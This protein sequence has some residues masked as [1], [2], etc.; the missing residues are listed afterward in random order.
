MCYRCIFRLL[1]LFCLT[2]SASAQSTSATIS[3]QVTDPSGRVIPGADIQILNEATGVRYGNTSNGIGIYSVSILPPGQYRVQVSKRGFKTLIKPDVILNVQS[4]VAVNFTMPPG[5]ASE[6]ITVD[7]GTS[8][9]NSVD[10]SVSTVIDK[11]F[12]ENMPLN[13]RS[14]Q[15][16][17][18]LTPGITTQ[19]PQTQYQAPGQN[20]DFSVNGQRTESNNYM[21]DGV[22]GNVNPGAAIGAPQASSSG[23][24]GATTALGTT[25]SLISVDA[26]Q[27]FRVESSSYSAEFGRTP[28]GQ[29]SLQTRAGTNALHGAIFDYLRNNFFDANDWF[30]N[31]YGRPIAALRQNDFGGTL[32]GPATIPRTYSGKDRTF[33]FGSYEGLRLVQ[34][35]AATPQ[36][37]PDLSMRRQAPDVLRPILNAYPVPNGI[38]YGTETDPNLAQFIE[39]YS[40]PSNIDSTSVRIDHTF[41]PL[42]S[43]FFRFGNTPSS[44]STRTLSVLNRVHNNTQTYTLGA[45]SAFSSLLV[46]EFRIG[47]SR[48]D[49]DTIGA[50]DAFGGA[51]PTSL[52]TAFGNQTG[53]Y[54]DSSFGINIPTI[55]YALLETDGS[56]NSIRQWN[57]VNNT[58]IALGRHQLKFGVDYRRIVSPF[59]PASPSVASLYLTPQSVL[60]NTALFVDIEKAIG[61]T[62]TFNETSVFAQD[63]WQLRPNLHLSFGVRWEINPPP[64]ESNGNLPYTLEGNIGQPATLSL[65]SKGTALWKTT[66]LNFAPRLGVS[67]TAHKREGAETVVSAGGGVFFDTDNQLAAS[68]F[69]GLGFRASNVLYGAA[70][71]VTATQLDSVSP[72]NVAAPYTS[73]IPYVF[74]SHLQLPYTLEWNV[75]LQQALGKLQAITVSYVGANGRR[76]IQQQIVSVSQANPL[77]G[78]VGYIPNGLTSSYQALQLKFQRTVHSGINALAAYTWSHS[79]DF[80]SNNASL[81]VARGNSDFDVR[82]SLQAGLSWDVPSPYQGRLGKK[83]FG[84]WGLDGRL[85]ARSG[86]PVTLRGNTLVNPV[87]GQQYYSGVN[88]DPSKPVYLFGG[89]YPGGRAINGG[90]SAVNPA[91]TA[92]PGTTSGNASRNFVRGFGATQFN[93]AL[94]R[95]FHLYDRASL[96]FRAEAFNVSN[97]PNFGYVNSILSNALFGQATGMLNQSLG[98][99]SSLY[100]QGGPRSMQLAL[101][102]IF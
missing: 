84:Q 2:A 16:L 3:G 27:E 1:L 4:A 79:L 21:V 25:Q 85:I 36:Y 13:G 53:K 32:G 88:Y 94:R 63:E 100:Q 56:R 33:F 11:T 52:A 86:F 10:S 9:V 34:P 18:S 14:F 68:G 17:I 15:D 96:Q 92:P 81:P 71:P 40:L 51:T 66:W 98:S 43:L 24:V 42:L 50:V 49:A 5:A 78:T 47:Y 82:N 31:Y 70:L 29:F 95:Q 55:G 39:S 26:L 90:P 67:W 28:G 101:K 45:T 30:N 77:F 20:G 76:L 48:G 12:V 60:A 89:Q 57:L 87:N 93:V 44:F 61:A 73:S 69:N 64:G 99:L 75:S 23:S 22:S 58:T 102:V 19:S 54:S 80:G 97:H 8:A 38:D 46:N 74:L 65:A 37:V 7:T 35:Q 6:S 91:F 72:A 62:P 41:G 59:T 83:I